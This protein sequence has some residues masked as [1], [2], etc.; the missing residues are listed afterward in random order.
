MSE[1]QS[2]DSLHSVHVA[3]PKLF[4]NGDIL[5]LLE[6]L[7]TRD[8]VHYCDDSPYGPYWS[9]TRYSDIMQVD[10]DYETFSS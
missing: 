5:E 2:Q 8:P 10:K 6:M 3:D 1:V 9:I 7:R 4:F